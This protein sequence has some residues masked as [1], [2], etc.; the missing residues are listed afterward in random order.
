MHCNLVGICAV[1]TEVLESDNAF[2]FEEQLEAA[3]ELWM[4]PHD[5]VEL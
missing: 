3:L 1:A 4:M 2:L 5:K